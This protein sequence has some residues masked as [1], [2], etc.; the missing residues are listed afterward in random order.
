MGLLAQVHTFE[1]VISIL[2]LL[3]SFYFFFS[4]AKREKSEI[5]AAILSRDLLVSLD[6]LNLTY[7]VFSNISNFEAL[8]SSLQLPLHYYPFFSTQNLINKNIIVAANCSSI[9]EFSSWFGEIYLN[10]KKVRI[11]FISTNLESLPSHADVLLICDYKNLTKY[12]NSLLS[13]LNKGKGIVGFFDVVANMDNTTKKIFGIDS[14]YYNLKNGDVKV[15]KPSSAKETSYLSYK[16]FYGLP[17]PVPFAGN[18]C[19]FT[20]RNYSVP[21]QVN[22]EEKKVNFLAGSNSIIRVGERE[23]F[24]LY[25]YN[26]LLAYIGNSSIYISFLKEYNFTNFIEG[27]L[28]PVTLDDNM[29]RV[30]LYQVEDI[31][32]IPVAVLNS[33]KVAWVAKFNRNNV[34]PHDKRLVLLTLLLA[35]SD[36]NF[37]YGRA[38]ERLF[39]VPF[40][41]VENYDI[42]EMYSVRFGYNPI[43]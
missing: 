36:K 10:R 8:T 21:F 32:M 38:S 37:I 4:I 33:T 6:N 42:C 26:F 29:K 43:Y 24:N 20:F 35:L 27:N 18:S 3:T 13:F 39:L 16:Y 28:I 41:D 14:S 30:F 12:E 22:V 9:E 1:I 15:R 5:N 31:G 23:K 25:G 7:S 11:I 17:I 40:I 19:I 2:L 34:A